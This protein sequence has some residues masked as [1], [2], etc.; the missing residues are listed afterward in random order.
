M[1]YKV[2]VTS[3]ALWECRNELSN[4][5]SEVDREGKDR[6]KL[7]HDRVHFPKT[8][9]QIDL[10]KCF[11]DA[12]MRGR[13]NREEFSQ[14]FNDAEEDGDEVIGHDFSRGLIGVRV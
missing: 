8:I 4:G 10:Q 13:A 7:N 11:G 2:T 6:T 1:S 9:V 3:F 14:S 5:S 12:Q